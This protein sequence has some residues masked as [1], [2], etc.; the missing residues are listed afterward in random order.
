MGLAIYSLR[1]GWRLQLFAAAYRL[2]VELRTRFMPGCRCRARLLPAPAHRRPDGPGHQRRRR[3]GDGRRRSHAR[4][5]RRH[6]DAGAGGRDDDAG[7]RLAAGGAALLPFPL[8][9]L[10][11]WWISRH[12]HEACARVA[13]RFGAPERPRAGTLAGVRTVRALGLQARSEREFARAGA[14]SAAEASFDAQ[15]WEAAYEPAVGLTLDRGHRAHAG[16]SAAGWSGSDELTIGQLTSF[17][18]YLGQL[19]WPMFAAGWVLSLLERGKAAW[20]RLQ[21]VLDAPLTVDD[22]GTHAHVAPGPL[23][24]RGRALH[25]IPARPRPA[26]DGVSLQLGARAARWAWSAPPAPASRRCCGCC[27]A[28]TRRDGHAALER[29]SACRTTPWPPCAPPS[30]GCRRSRSC[31]RP[32]VAENIALARPDATRARGRA[33]G[34]GWPPCTTTSCA[35]RKATTRRWASAA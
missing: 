23:A 35:C 29:P 5:L 3:G 28:T 6:A 22:H 19:I 2:G 10:R 8:M 4:R 33:G 20:A 13:R 14:R 26:L 12:V 18:L 31:S 27:C 21:P 17:S 7:R 34:A 24:L 1:V 30:P 15:R 11:F 16:R 32:S 9:A 25:A